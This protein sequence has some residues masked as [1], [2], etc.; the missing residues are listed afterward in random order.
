VEPE[1]S[2][3]FTMVVVVVAAAVAPV[4]VVVTVCSSRVNKRGSKYLN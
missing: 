4:V 1:K 3:I 2:L